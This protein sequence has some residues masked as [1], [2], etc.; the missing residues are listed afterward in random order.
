MVAGYTDGRYAWSAADWARFPDADKVTIT[1]LGRDNA[2]VLNLEPNGYWP[3]D[4]GVAWVR[5]ARARGVDPSIYC[6][7]RN[8]LRLVKAAFDRAGEPYP[9]FWV[10]EY[11]G[12]T[13]IPEGCVAKQFAAPEGTGAAHTPGHYDLSIVA[14]YWPGVDPAPEPVAPQPK[15]VIDL[16]G[17]NGYALQV[18][19]GPLTEADG[20]VV[21]EGSA[22]LYDSTTGRID[23]HDPD[24][25]RVACEK[26][27]VLHIGCEG[28]VVGNLLNAAV[29]PDRVA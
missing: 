6:N 24:A 14:D 17:F 18:T 15:E 20:Y 25:L 22:W 28:R 13:V 26:A 5:R 4:L 8:H 29:N 9:H 2:T 23:Y 21:P 3:A 1:A 12:V 16:S 7:Y 19:S 10:A 27:G 11:D